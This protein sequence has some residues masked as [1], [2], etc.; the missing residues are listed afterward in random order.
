MIIYPVL[1][2]IIGLLLKG[3]N[4]KIHYPLHHRYH[5]VS[6]IGHIL[7]WFGF[8]HH[9]HQIPHTLIVLA[10]ASSILIEAS[11]ID[12]EYQE[13]PNSYNAMVA[14]LGGAFIWQYSAFYQD[15]LLSGVIAFVVFFVIMMLTGAMGGGDVKMAGAIGLF[16]P[17]GLV[18]N[19]IF[20][21]FLIGS[22]IAIALLVLRI[23]KKD[24]VFPF[25]P[26]I[27]LAGIWMF[28]FFV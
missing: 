22:I 19:F 2:F 24:D 4:T 14:I 15:L 1:G 27:A 8:H 20:Y 17:L 25:G 5:W 11:M 7:I 18:Q 9:Y 21:A 26:A 12:L 13:I 28:M 23:K 10:L 3:L 16:M 6:L